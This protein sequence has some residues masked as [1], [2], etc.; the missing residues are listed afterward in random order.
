MLLADRQYFR[1]SIYSIAVRRQ[2]S[3]KIADPSLE[4][5]IYDKLYLYAAIDDSIDRRHT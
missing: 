3:L 1:L 5:H 4:I 2:N